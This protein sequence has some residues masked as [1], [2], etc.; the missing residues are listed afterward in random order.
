VDWFE[1]AE[2]IIEGS[3][4]ALCLYLFIV[5]SLTH[6]QPFIDLG[7]FRDGNFLAGCT[8]MAMIGTI[9]LSTLAL[10]PP[11]MQNLLGYPALLT[12]LVLAPRGAGTMVGMMIVGRLGRR[13]DPRGLILFGLGLTAFSLHLMSDFTPDVDIGHVFWT[14]M[15]QGFGFGF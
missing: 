3:I 15:V 6:K 12:G 2:I 11:F 8:F 7:I 4:F 9:L 13:V 14:G 1:S 5:H 10:Y